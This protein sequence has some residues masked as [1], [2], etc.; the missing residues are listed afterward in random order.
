MIASIYGFTVNIH[1]RTNTT[2]LGAQ[3]DSVGGRLESYQH[4]ST[5]T[6]GY[7]SATLTLTAADLDEALVWTE[8]LLCPVLAYGPGA[9]LIWDGYISQVELRVG[10]RT[11]SYSLDGVANRVRCR[12]TTVLGTPGVTAAV[13]NVASVALYGVRD[14][15]IS[16]GTLNLASAQALR[17][18]YLVDHAFP[19]ARPTTT[20]RNGDATG[21]GVALTLTCA[22]WYA[23][24]GAVMLARTDTA[25]EATTAQLA[26]LIG[27]TTPGIGVTNGW[28]DPSTV[29]I[30]TTGVVATRKIEEDTSYRQAIETRLGMGSTANVRYAWGVYGARQFVVR[31]WAG[32]TPGT[33]GYR[34]RLADASVMNT[35]GGAVELWQVRPDAMVEDSDLVSAAPPSGAVE[36]GGS[37]YVERVTF[38]AQRGGMELELEPSDNTNLTARL[39]RV[40]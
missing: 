10:D 6:F 5:A 28:L 36:G 2:A 16:L 38:S 20:L 11:R 22:G 26:T 34:V 30:V 21:G 40:S 3:I 18:A 14:A 7:E 4:T 1:A 29:E 33:A 31:P 39:A 24:L 19:R 27:A 12:Y 25:T 9:D 37:F 15:V 8:R 17:D 35:G 32:A 13:S 23:T